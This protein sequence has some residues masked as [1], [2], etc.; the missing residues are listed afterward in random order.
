MQNIKFQSNTTTGILLAVL[1]AFLWGTIPLA[2]VYCLVY[3]DGVTITWFRFTV[4]AVVCFI[5]QL[6][7]DRLK[8]FSHLNLKE[9]SILILAGIFLIVDYVAYTMALN[10]ISP[11]A[12]TIFSQATPFFLCIGGVIVFKERL[13]LV[14]VLSFIVLLSLIHI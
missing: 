10:Y 6:H 13:N 2:L 4:A 12:T 3:L 7:K 14:Q 1:T 11:V 8:E 5:W 9:W